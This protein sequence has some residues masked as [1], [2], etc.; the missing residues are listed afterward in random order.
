MSTVAF[1]SVLPPPGPKALI[2]YVARRFGTSACISVPSILVPR[3]SV[4]FILSP[5]DCVV[6]SCE[7]V[8]TWQ[9]Q[10]HFTSV[11]HSS[12]RAPELSARLILDTT[13]NDMHGIIDTSPVLY[14]PTIPFIIDRSCSWSDAD[15]VCTTGGCVATCLTGMVSSCVAVG[16]AG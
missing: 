1:T 3:L 9:Q 7:T 2:L 15:I 11:V 13:E 14:W 6:L 12:R 16:G 10:Q 4:P 5:S 8:I